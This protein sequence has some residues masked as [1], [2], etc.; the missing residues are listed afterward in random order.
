[1]NV[2][3]IT[4]VSS[5]FHDSSVVWV[6]NGRIE[7]AVSEE[8]FTRIKHDYCFP[9]NS[10]RHVLETS[11]L[12]PNEFEGVAIAWRP[13]NPFSGFFQRNVLDVP[14]TLLYSLATKPGPMLAYVM[15][16]FVGKK[17]IGKPS[18]LSNFGFESSRLHYFSHHL[19]H[20]ASSYRTSGYN[21]ALSVNLDCFGPD[22][23]GHLWSGATFA[24]EGNKI[25]LV[26]Y[27]P[28]FASLGL[29]YSAVSVGL[30]F[31]FGD[32]EGKT[33]GLAA[34]GDPAIAYSDLI[35]VSPDFREGRWYGP[36]AW[37]DFRLIDNPQLLYNTKWGRYLR[38]VIQK[39]GREHVAAGAQRILEEVLTRYF[40]HL[41]AVTG[42][43]SIVLAGGIFLNIK[44]NQKLVERNDVDKVFVHPFPSDGGTAAGAALELAARLSSEDVRYE[45]PSAALGMTYS[46]S[47]IEGMIERY[48]DKIES[49][50]RQDVPI[51]AARLISEGKIVGWFQ[52]RSEWG[53]RALGYRSVLGDPRNENSK[54]RLNKLLKSRDWFMPFAPSV[55]EEYM[56][57]YFENAFY[58]PFMTF[59]FNVRTAKKEIIPAVSHNDGT[60]RPNTVRK[61]VNPRYYELIDSF[62]KMT[63][64]PMVLN[65]SFNRHGL[66]LVN[67]PAE[68]IDHLLWGCI[69]VLILEDY[70]IRRKVSVEDVD[71]HAKRALMDAYV[72]D[73]AF[74]AAFER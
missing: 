30:G 19:A 6:K 49:N 58:S 8:R 68:A 57:E 22:D 69:D 60:A 70:V 24:C 16:N 1:M 55:L 31:K 46:A 39:R 36:A 10:L 32:G 45:M 4:S 21:E 17:L 37:T 56:N 33:M 15:K 54:E 13:Y 23:E 61:S 73:T 50:K 59:S 51:E 47:D 25:S 3:G 42:K 74:A 40:D 53:P 34:Y 12:R 43:K 26:E 44:F 2:L 66:P 28:A 62:R 67:T 11:G 72:D 52:G 27:I 20:A 64:V 65:T 29:F 9:E 5:G 7:L 71:E 35:M 48:G 14:A 18:Q 63:G 38:R 41:L